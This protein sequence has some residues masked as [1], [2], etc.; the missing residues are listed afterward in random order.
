ML[1][2]REMKKEENP[3]SSTEIKD[4]QE[5]FSRLILDIQ[6]REG[7][8]ESAAVLK[9]ASKKMDTNP[10]F[11]QALA[12]V[13]YIELKDYNKAEMW[14]KEAKKRDP[15]S[16]FVA[17]TLGQVHKNHLNYLNPLNEKRKELHFVDRHRT[18]L[19]KGVRDTGAIL[20]K[21]MDEELISNETYDAVRALTTP[22]D[23][24][25]EILRFVSSAGR[26]SKDAFYQIIKGMKNLKHL[27]SELQ[28]SR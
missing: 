25:R 28:G 8:V 14:A 4:E 13:Y 24:M 7:N 21:L 5:R 18:A 10:F 17:D 20:D 2:K 1:T 3:N 19:I 26:R 15:Q 11:P 9:V 16:S 12:R 27:I 6:K 23:Q 22:Q